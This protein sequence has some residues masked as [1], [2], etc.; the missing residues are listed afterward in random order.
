MEDVRLLLTPEQ[1]DKK[2]WLQEQHKASNFAWK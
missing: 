2:G 1:D